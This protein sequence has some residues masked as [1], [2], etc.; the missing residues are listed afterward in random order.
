MSD[1]KIML[2]VSFS[3]DVIKA[4]QGDVC[5]DCASLKQARLSSKLSQAKLGRRIGVS[6]ATIW[7]WE[8]GLI[9]IRPVYAAA[10]RH[11]LQLEDVPGPSPSDAPAS[12]EPMKR[13]AS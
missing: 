13:H 11:V 6:Q 9:P 12:S 10:I 4:L 2:E 7:R 5:M 1:P 3:S 8:Q